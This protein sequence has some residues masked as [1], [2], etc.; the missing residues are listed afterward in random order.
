MIT[1][2]IESGDMFFTFFYEV[3][4]VDV[5]WKLQYFIFDRYLALTA[6]CFRTG[7]LT[8]LASVNSIL[9]GGD[10]QIYQF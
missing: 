1:F 8:A 5:A 10:V 9:G 3:R 6:N 2:T 4:A 7:N